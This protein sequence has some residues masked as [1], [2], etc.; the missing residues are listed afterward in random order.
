MQ[1]AHLVAAVAAVG[2][3]R[4]KKYLGMKIFRFLVALAAFVVVWLVV[5][6]LL[7]LATRAVLPGVSGD[8]PVLGVNWATLPGSALGV[9]AGYRIFQM[10]VG[11]RQ[12]KA[13]K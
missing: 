8:I 5:T 4:R 1:S 12:R 6:V 13:A 3:V 9:L 11:G 2:V 7:G 10:L